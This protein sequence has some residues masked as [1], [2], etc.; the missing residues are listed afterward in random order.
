MVKLG[1]VLGWRG[2]GSMRAPL[3]VAE[4]DMAVR[5]FLGSG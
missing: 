4:T 2:L 5:R 1:L 3:L